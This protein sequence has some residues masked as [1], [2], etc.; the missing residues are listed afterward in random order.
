MSRI[1]PT[2]WES[3]APEQMKEAV[4][5]SGYLLERRVASL[6]HKKGYR[7]FTNRGFIDQE[8]QK[9]TDTHKPREYDV[10]AYREITAY[11]KGSYGIFPTL[12]CECKNNSQPFVFFAQEKKTFEP[13][14][15][16]VRVSGIPSKIWRRNRYISIQEFTGVESFHHYCRPKVP[17]AS[18]YC[19]F[20]KSKS[21]KSWIAQHEKE[22]RDTPEERKT[23]PSI[24]TAMEY[25]IDQDFKYMSQWFVPNETE[26][27]FIDLSFYYPVVIFQ[28][29]I[30]AVYIGKDVPSGQDNLTFEK[31]EHVQFNPDF[32]SYYSREVNSYHIDVISEKYLSDYLKII[33][34]EMLAVKK[35]LEQEKD[36]VLLS[37]DKIVEE[38]RSL[39]VKPDTYRE[40]LEFKF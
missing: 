4:W 23:F 36:S 18:Q 34:R 17:V 13:L 19:T 8:P 7:V 15:D 30:Y 2:S 27:Q 21:G 12:I 20:D 33:N 37:V 6:L 14:K 35:I 1:T 31:R 24:I 16:E 22:H 29:D 38:C 11:E 39:K 26:R 32:V 3:I 5:N 10:C 40:Y 9:D 28:G 25:E